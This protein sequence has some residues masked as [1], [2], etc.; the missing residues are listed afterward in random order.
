MKNIF[1]IFKKEMRDLLRDRRTLMAMIIIPFC[2]IPVLFT[3]MSTI[4]SSQAESA[5]EKKIKIA[6]YDF[7]ENS[8]LIEKYKFRKDIKLYLD[9]EYSRFRELV[10]QDSLDFGI[11]IGDPDR[12]FRDDIEGGRTGEVSVF[13]KASADT[14]LYQ[15]AVNTINR[16]KQNVLQERLSALGANQST[17]T[18]IEVVPRNVYNQRES[19]G[20]L[21][22]GLLPYFFVLFCFVG[23]MYPAIDL[24]TGEKERGTIETLLVVPANR[25]HILIGKMM[26]VITAGVISGLLTI[27]GLFVALKVAPNIDEA[28]AEIVLQILTPSSISLVILMMIPLTTFFAGILIPA[29]IYAKSF[30]EAQ[31]VI[32][33]MMILAIVPLAIGML[34][35]IELTPLTAAIPV[36]N[37]ALAS[38]EI[39]AGTLDYGLLA[40][41]FASLFV[42]AAIGIMLCRRWFGSE[43]N[44]LRV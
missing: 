31:S 35:G 7:D 13:Y 20:K 15:R 17:I 2:L 6:L 12:S 11:I 5:R 32:Q 40:I 26:V 22:G 9:I 18:P 29:S 19:F 1:T 23:A 34:P 27:V 4:T 21:A 28:I 41:V 16:Y 10:Y 38:K 42:L 37:V 8:E 43:G 30:K 33:P 25:L 3:L 14:I 24:F 44:I 36:L 39:I